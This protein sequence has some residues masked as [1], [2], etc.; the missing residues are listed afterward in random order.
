[1]IKTKVE[2]KT[3]NLNPMQVVGLQVQRF[4]E[5]VKTTFGKIEQKLITKSGRQF[6]GA[7]SV[8]KDDVAYK[9]C[10]V[11]TDEFEHLALGLEL[12]MLPGGKYVTNK[13]VNW[14]KNTHLIKEVFSEMEFKYKFDAQ[15]PQ[16]EYY[17]NNRE[18]ILMLPIV[19]REEQLKIDFFA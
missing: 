18:L 10:M 12:Y 8:Q 13:L 15:R 14:S 7:L 17:K 5:D 16:L 1:M 6:F 3:V 2:T 19:P 11:P 4:P 9:A